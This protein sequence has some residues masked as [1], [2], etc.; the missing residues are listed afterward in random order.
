M[1]RAFTSDPNSLLVCARK[2]NVRIGPVLGSTTRCLSGLHSLNVLMPSK[3]NL[4]KSSW[5]LISGVLSQY[6]SQIL[7]L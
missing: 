5:V 1:Q 6:A 4:Q 2:D 3:Q 7:N